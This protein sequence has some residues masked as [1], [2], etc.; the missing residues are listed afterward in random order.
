[1]RDLVAV[2]GTLRKGHGNW[3]WSYKHADEVKLM[4]TISGYVMRT[5][6]GFPAVFPSGDLRDKVCVD[7]FDVTDI[8]D[9]QEEVD[10]MEYGAGYDK[11][12]V[13]TDSG[14]NV[15]L[16]VGDKGSEDW[17]TEQIPSGNWEDYER[18]CG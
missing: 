11:V 6:G 12:A 1:M 17:H 7:V 14:Y 3:G 13:T 4:D 10:G 2:Y 5:F 15:W 8:P 18:G 9:L 16:F